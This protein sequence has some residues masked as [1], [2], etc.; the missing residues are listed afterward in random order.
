MSLSVAISVLLGL[1]AAL[2]ISLEVTRELGERGSWLPAGWRSFV[3]GALTAA[4]LLAL[5]ATLSLFHSVA[6]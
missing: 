6:A 5:V 4:V 1:A 2:T 3:T